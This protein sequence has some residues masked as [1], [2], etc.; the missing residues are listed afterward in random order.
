MLVCVCVCVYV[1]D[2]KLEG[3]W[4]QP[5]LGVYPCRRVRGVLKDQRHN[6]TQLMRNEP[7]YLIIEGCMITSLHGN[8]PLYTRTSVLAQRHLLIKGKKVYARVR[9]LH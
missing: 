8:S 2:K 3:V 1:C 6:H 9:S 5:G 4:N 7:L